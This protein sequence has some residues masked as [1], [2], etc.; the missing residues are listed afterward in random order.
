[1]LFGLDRDWDGN[2]NNDGGGAFRKDTVTNGRNQTVGVVEMW[3]G[4][5][6]PSCADNNSWVPI[7]DPDF[8]DVTVFTVNDGES[9]SEDYVEEGGVTLTKRERL[10]KF[11]LGGRL[12]LDN[13][14]V[15]QIEDTIKLR[16]DFYL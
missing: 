12:I 8:V 16:N 14:I 3:V 15:R 10:V 6:T 9:F 5:G 11:Q 2:A 4:T 1:M 13:D 7:T